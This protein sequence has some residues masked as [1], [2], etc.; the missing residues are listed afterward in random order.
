[1]LPTPE[2]Y[3]QILA[4][5]K[6][7]RDP[8]LRWKI[9]CLIRGLRG[10]NIALTSARFGIHRTTCYRWIR[11][12]TA[13][14]FEPESLRPR[15]RRPHH[16]PRRLQGPVTERILWYRTTYHYGPDRIGWYLT[17]QEDSPVSSHGVYNVLKREGISFRKR[18]DQK[19]NPHRRR[20]DLDH[21]GQGIQLDIKYVP[22]RIE[23][24]KAYVFN[25]LDDCSRWRFQW[26]YRK[27]GNDS[28]LDF[29]QRLLQAAP[30]PIETLQ[31]DNDLCFTNRFQKIPKVDPAEPHPFEQMLQA[32]GIHHK[33]LPPGQK[34][35]NGK[36]ERSHKTDDQEF[37]WLLPSWISFPEFRRQLQ[38]WTFEYNH[39]RPH[40][41]LKMKTPVQRLADFGI[42]PADSSAGTWSE[43]P[44][45]THYDQILRKLRDYRRDHPHDPFLHW[46]FKPH[47]AP[48]RTNPSW[49]PGTPR[50][51]QTLS[52]MNG[53]TTVCGVP[54]SP[55]YSYWMIFQSFP[56]SVN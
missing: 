43:P 22:F 25:A 38:R 31:T 3:S 6:F 30:F 19:L 42:V 55:A 49:L 8:S 29:L 15:S 41:S 27:K 39:F 47:G 26:A 18:K 37:Y 40:S 53:K 14:Q 21:P 34:E 46:Q 7:V 50:A 52:Q 11:R 24:K 44:K 2:L 12:L 10:R 36:V 48:L 4:H 33:L 56:S 23:E 32:R 9:E 13:G 5:S 20:Y 17:H 16:H 51:I 1:M 28:S 54:G 35:L 45:P